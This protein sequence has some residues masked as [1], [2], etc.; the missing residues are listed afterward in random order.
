MTFT[1]VLTLFHEFGHCLQH[2]SDLY[3]LF[4]H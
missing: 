3:I 1:D 2:V 4:D